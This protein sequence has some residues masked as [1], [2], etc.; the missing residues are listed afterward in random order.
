MDKWEYRLL[1]SK[2]LPEAEADVFKH[3]KVTLKEAEMYLNK[4][5][6]EGWEVIHIDSNFLLHDTGAF[7]GIAKRKKA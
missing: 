3:A 7:V 5:G 1:A 6:E 2:N 4:L